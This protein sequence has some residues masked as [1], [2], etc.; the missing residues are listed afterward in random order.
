MQNSGI[1]NNLQSAYKCGNSTETALLYIQNDILS[2]QDRGE[3][4]AL[5]L[6]DY[7]AAF[8]TIDHDLLLSRLTEWFGIDGVVL[9]WVRS[10]VTGRSQLVKVNGV[11][12][13]P[14]LLLCGVPQGSVLGPLLF[15]MHTTPLSSIITAF[16][17]KHHLYADDTQ[18]YT[19]FVAEDRAQSLNFVQNCMLAI[20]VW[21]NQNMLKLNASKT[22]LFM[23]IG[24][25]TQRK[26]VAH[27]FPVELLN[28]S[29]AEINSIRNLGVAFDP[30]FSF[31]KHVSNICRSAFYHIRDLRRIRIHLNNATA[32][33]LANA[34]VSSRRDYCNS[35]LFG[36]SAFRV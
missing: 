18:I 31:K 36:C 10:Y 27:I 11:L 21:M 30:A 33:S 19:S 14:Q 17:L 29:F 1:S 8:D 26:K 13:T 28:Q 22:E 35:L 7:S 25:L 5:S 4:T 23:I 24:N 12:R 6:L 16:G 15:T 34:L 2:A 9:Q 3:L 32:I 20:Q